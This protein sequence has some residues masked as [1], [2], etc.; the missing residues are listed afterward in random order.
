MALKFQDK[1][2]PFE[3]L[4][5]VKESDRPF[6]AVNFYLMGGCVVLIILGFLFMSGGGSSIEGGF[7]PDIFSTRRIVVGPLLS[8]L[9]FLLMAFAIIY[10]PEKGFGKFGRAIGSKGEKET[11]EEA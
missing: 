8:F 6:S 11:K 5:E 10:D 4:K 7:N 9:G 3:T 2:K 1:K